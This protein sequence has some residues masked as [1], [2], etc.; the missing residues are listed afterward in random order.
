MERR[1]RRRYALFALLACAAVA[2]AVY[3]I[4]ATSGAA[5]SAA[6]SSSAGLPVGA[7]VV[8][9]R[10][11]SLAVGPGGQL[12]IADDR[13]NQILEWTGHGTFRVVAGSGRAGFSG[14]G[15]PAL[16]ARLDQPGGMTVAPDGTLY[17][18]DT[19]NGRIR[20]ISPAGTITTIAGDGAPR[21][22]TRSTGSR[23]AARRTTRRARARPM[24]WRSA[25][26]AIST[27][28]AAPT[29]C[30]ACTATARS[31][32]VAGSRNDFAGSRHRRTSDQ[33]IAGRAV[34]ARVRLAR[35]P[36]H[37]RQRHQ[38]AADGHARAAA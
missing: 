23:T 27:S 10:P 32:I 13:R 8:P 11:S 18:A 1:R 3:A 25:L 29:R 16:R 30:C 38:D 37:Q 36:V 24:T 6:G 20:V 28:M 34:R 31:S 9:E 4:V 17:F 26:V 21:D 12:Y 15:G 35:R 14:D 7:R 33:G 5:T 19:G 22:R 2:G